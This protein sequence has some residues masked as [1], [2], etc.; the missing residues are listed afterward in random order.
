MDSDD[1]IKF[2]VIGHGHIGQRHCAMIANN[3]EAKLIAV[4]DSN[5]LQLKSIDSSRVATY[6][7][8]DELLANHSEELDIVCICTPNNLHTQ[9]ALLCINN[10]LHVIIEKPM[11]L[12]KADAEEVIFRSLQKQ[13]LV[14]CVMQ[15]RYS[16]PS[17]WLKSLMEEKKLG[18]I[19]HIQV[20]CFWNRDD[21]YY[22]KGTWRG[23]LNQDG[24][25]L[26]TQFSH[27]IDLLFW[28]F[29]D[30]DDISAVFADFNHQEST[31]F[32]DT[33]IV[34][35]RFKNKTLGTINYSTAVWDSNMESSISIIGEKGSVKVS[36]QYM[37]EVVYCHI[38][39]YTM[40]QLE[41]TS[42]PNDYGAYKGSA[43]N[44]HYVIQNVIDTLKQKSIATTNALEGLKVVEIIERI[45]K[46]RDNTMNKNA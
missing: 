19:Y 6:T 2:A 45:Y 15:N 37:N 9:Q 25:T 28:L 31:D 7:S 12:S 27:F 5:P 43:A 34:T 1:I 36:G 23:S 33:G 46:L 35:L 21:R 8:I 18:E 32:E 29:G 14:F 3:P 24:G 22:Q 41:N 4:A 16:P 20:N 11:A 13:K 38:K 10:N 40:P 30:I 44:H 26:F 17:Q 42:P 39:E